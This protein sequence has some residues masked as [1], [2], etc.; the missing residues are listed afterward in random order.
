MK[1]LLNPN[2]QVLAAT[3][4]LVMNPAT[5]PWWGYPGWGGYGYYGGYPSYPQQRV[6]ERVPGDME[7]PD[8]TIVR[9]NADGTK[10]CC[11]PMSYGYSWPYYPLYS[12]PSFRT[13][14]FHVKPKPSN[15]NGNVQPNPAK[16]C[17]DGH[18][19]VII[20]TNDSA[21]MFCAAPKPGGGYKLTK[22]M[23]SDTNGHMP[24]LVDGNGNAVTTILKAPDGHHLEIEG[25]NGSPVVV[26]AV[27]ESGDLAA[28]IVEPGLSHDQE[29]QEI[30][31]PPQENPRVCPHW[32]EQINLGGGLVRC[33]RCH[34][35][36]RG[37]ISTVSA[38]MSNPLYS[39]PL[40]WYYPAY[41]YYYPYYYGAWPYYYAWPYYWG[42]WPY[43]YGWWPFFQAKGKITGSGA[44]HFSGGSS[45]AAHFSGN[46]GP[47]FNPNL[48]P[49]PATT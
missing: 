12:Y 46:P 40:Y 5:N 27:S 37:G 32:C 36:S 25:G 23:Q 7:C 26:H 43:G 41:G 42:S 35:P 11:P 28:P 24:Y 8:G 6:C 34:P 18:V 31:P 29:A 16:R 1:R 45:G 13:F 49:N 20:T 19:L 33:V 4:Q 10:T 21:V 44:A 39:W 14:T 17:P 3:Q 2:Q 48:N 30:T 9:R 22:P 15:G 38:R 47:H